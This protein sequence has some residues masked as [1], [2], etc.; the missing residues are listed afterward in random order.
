[1]SRHFR[2]GFD[3]ESI[4][5]AYK[6]YRDGD[7]RKVMTLT[8]E[9]L[10]RRFLLHVLRKCFIRVHHFGFLCNRCRAHRLRAIRTTPA[11]PAPTAAEP[12]KPAA[13]FGGYPCPN[14]RESRFHV[15]KRVA[16]QRRG[17]GVRRVTAPS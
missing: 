3:G 10:I 11:T 1:M 7:R 6:D 17:E 5:H 9:E 15:T 14:C 16:P 8:G 2:S 4:D 12:S 13:Q